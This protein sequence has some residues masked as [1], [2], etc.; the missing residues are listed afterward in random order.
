MSKPICD[1]SIEELEAALI[2][3]NNKVDALNQA[4]KKVALLLNAELSKKT[5]AVS[6]QKKLAG[7]SDEEKKQL[8]ALLGPKG[9]EPGKVG[10]PGT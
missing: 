1:M 9:I 3:H 8:S 5:A 10:T 6:L 2:D 7:M 4:E